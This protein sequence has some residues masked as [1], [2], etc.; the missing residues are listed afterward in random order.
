VQAY[1]HPLNDS[2]V[3]RMFALIA[4]GLA[5]PT[6]PRDQERSPQGLLAVAP[7]RRSL[8][9]RIDHW[10]WQRNQHAV[11]AYLGQSTDVFE[12]EARIRQLEH[13]GAHEHI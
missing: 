8:L 5:L 6:R 4:E 13:D 7:A 11:D 2:G 9:E 1:R 12:L 10:F 3:S